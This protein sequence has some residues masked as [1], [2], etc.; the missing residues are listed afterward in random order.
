MAYPP[1]AENVRS[2]AY[3]MTRFLYM[4]VR[5]RPTGSA[6]AYIDWILSDEGQSVVQSIG[7]FP[8]R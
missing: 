5:T 6:K 8:L 4:Y 7:Y 3:P 1:T 2:G